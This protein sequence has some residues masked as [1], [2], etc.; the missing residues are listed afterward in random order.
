MISEE[1]LKQG[2]A[3]LQNR[4]Q[5]DANLLAAYSEIDAQFS[6][7]LQDLRATAP[8]AA[9]ALELLNQKIDLMRVDMHWQEHVKRLP[10]R[11]V[12]LSATGMA[13]D[14]KV[15]LDEGRALHCNM[16][17]PSIAHSMEL[18]ARVISSRR[19]ENGG[20]RIGLDFEFLRDDDSEQLIRFTLHEQQQALCHDDE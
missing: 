13:F 8:R 15:S 1:T 5:A 14:Y 18:Y 20:F 10:L 16:T 12:N 17:L 3:E 7:L 2:I 11:Q 4:P 9:A 19:Q 6:V